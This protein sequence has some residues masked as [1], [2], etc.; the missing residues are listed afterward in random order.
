MQG[1]DGKEGKILL[2]FLPFP[3]LL[4]KDS[5]KWVIIAQFNRKDGI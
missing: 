2:P 3:I 4:F 1:K 5:E